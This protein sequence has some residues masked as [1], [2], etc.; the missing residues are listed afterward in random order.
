MKSNA[1]YEKAAKALSDAFQNGILKS[2]KKYGDRRLVPY[3]EEILKEAMLVLK[4]ETFTLA[5]RDAARVRLSYIKEGEPLYPEE[6]PAYLKEYPKLGGEL[7]MEN[8]IVS[9]YDAL[10][11]SAK[12]AYL[13]WFLK[14][15]P[16]KEK[17]NGRKHAPV[18]R[19]EGDKDE[20]I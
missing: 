9:L 18:L 6:C 1:E 19:K 4:D 8:Q 7:F 10:T 14:H 16:K 11:V 13:E 2:L 17:A 3:P 20:N 5:L 15:Y 12:G